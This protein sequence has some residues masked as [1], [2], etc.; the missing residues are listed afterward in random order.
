MTVADPC[1]DPDFD[2]ATSGISG[3]TMESLCPDGYIQ[4]QEEE[5]DEEDG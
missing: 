4:E 1:A 5:T 2:L 3:H